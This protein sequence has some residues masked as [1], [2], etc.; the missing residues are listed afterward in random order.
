[1][2]DVQ[3]YL[4]RLHLAMAS[5]IT[6][7]G[8]VPESLVTDW[9]DEFEPLKPIIMGYDSGTLRAAPFPFRKRSLL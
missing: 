2:Y 9:E 7:H 5:H 1:M 3:K 4:N 6:H 8:F